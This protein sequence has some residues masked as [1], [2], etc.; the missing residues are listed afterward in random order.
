MAVAAVGG[1]AL[2]VVLATSSVELPLMLDELRVATVP[3]KVAAKPPRFVF[4]SFF[5]DVFLGALDDSDTSGNAAATPDR[6]R[7]WMM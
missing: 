4:Q 6:A 3:T 5:R 1:L 7:C 2:R